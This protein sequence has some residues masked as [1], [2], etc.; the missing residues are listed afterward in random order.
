MSMYI[1]V[2]DICFILNRNC[3]LRFVVLVIK[4]DKTY[5]ICENLILLLPDM[6]GLEMATSWLEIQRDAHAS[7][8]V[9]K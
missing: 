7:L 9:K 1:L 6:Y 4:T 5:T 2:Q 3:L 8:L